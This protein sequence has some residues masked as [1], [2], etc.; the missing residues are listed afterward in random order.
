MKFLI[1]FSLWIAFLVVA[2]ASSGLVAVALMTR[3]D[4]GTLWFGNRKY[5]RGHGS[6]HLLWDNWL[7][8]WLFLCWRN[9]I[10]NFGHD[11]FPMGMA[12]M[13]QYWFIDSKI[14]GRVWRKYGWKGTHPPFTFIFRFYIR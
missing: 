7:G 3:W 6:P 12:A 10:S 13:K 1:S 5:P 8:Q 11:P 14:M 4:G 2:L 9:P